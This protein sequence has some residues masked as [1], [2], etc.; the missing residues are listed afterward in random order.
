MIII[1]QNKIKLHVALF[2]VELNFSLKERAMR[3]TSCNELL[4]NEMK[5]CS[6]TILCI[7]TFQNLASLLFTYY[8]R[9]VSED[10]L[11]LENNFW[12]SYSWGDNRK[13]RTVGGRA[14]HWTHSCSVV[15]SS[16]FNRHAAHKIYPMHRLLAFTS[17][18]S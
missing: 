12:L 2:L 3:S 5:N 13:I 4:V 10:A 18:G 1:T 8:Y 11:I 6:P 16:H 9:F 15:I 17:V 14:I 7:C